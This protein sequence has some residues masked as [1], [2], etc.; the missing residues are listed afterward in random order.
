MF[1]L[2]SGLIND[3]KVSFKDVCASCKMGK[4]KTLS[5][6][7]HDFLA[8]KCFDI[9]HSDVWGIAHVISHSHYKYFVTFIDD[10]SRFTWI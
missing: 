1:L 8:L 5:F 10:Y 2:N 9:V 3:N 6:P 4:G 7:L